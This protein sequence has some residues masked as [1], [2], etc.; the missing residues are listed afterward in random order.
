MHDRLFTKIGDEA[1]LRGTVPCLVNIER[2]VVVDYETGD[3]KFYRS[4]FAGVI[5]VANIPAK[6]SPKVGDTLAVG[7][8]S[9]VIDAIGADNGYMVRCVLR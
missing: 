1:V 8:K 2:G 6:H 7:L 9:Y 3:D 5:D 4:E